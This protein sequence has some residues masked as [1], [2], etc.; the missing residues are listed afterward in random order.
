VAVNED[1]VGRCR[2]AYIKV[3]LQRLNSLPTQ[4][5][6]PILQPLPLLDPRLFPGQIQIAQPQ[7]AY[8]TGAK[9]TVQHQ[10]HPGSIHQRLPLA[11]DFGVDFL[12]NL[13]EQLA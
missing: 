12:L 6:N 2:A 13:V 8:F 10:Q 9:T 4:E 7:M 11:F 3:C 5:N 1:V